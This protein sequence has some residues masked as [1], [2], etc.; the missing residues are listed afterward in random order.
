LKRILL[1]AMV[2]LLLLGCSGASSFQT[3]NTTMSIT[4]TNTTV[5]PGHSF[6]ITITISNANNLNGWQVALKY[7]A[8]IVNCTAAWI[9]ADN[10]FAN[11]SFIAV[12]P[13]LNDATVDG[14]NYS[15]CGNGLFSDDSV[16]VAQGTLCKLNFTCQKYGW[17]SLQLGTPSNPIKSGSVYLPTSWY[18]ELLDTNPTEMDFVAEDGFV[19]NGLQPVLTVVSSP[20]GTTNPSPGNYSRTA[21]TNAS[22]VATPD[23]THTFDHWL[24]D[25]SN[26]GSTNLI[27]VL[28]NANHTVEPV[29]AQANFALTIVEAT[30]GNTS[31]LPGTYTYAAGYLLQISATAYSGYVFSYW[32]LDGSQAGSSNPLPVTMNSNHTLRPVF[33]STL[34]A[35]IYI[36]VDGTIDPPGVPLS[37]LDNTTYEFTGDISSMITVQRSNITILG[38][39][40]SLQGTGSGSGIRLIGVN[41]VSIANLNIRGFDNGIDILGSSLDTISECNI[42]ANNGMGINLYNSCNNTASANNIE[43]NNEAIHLDYSSNYNSVIGNNIE[44]NGVRGIYV[45]SSSENLVYHNNFVNNT[46]Q[47]Y[48]AASGYSPSNSWDNGM[49]GNYWSNYLGADFNADGIGDTPYPIDANNTDHFP[50]LGTFSVFDATQG[51]SVAIVSNST[52]T[53]FNYS[54]LDKRI[55]FNVS[56]E[57][58]KIGFCELTIPH[59]L[60]DAERIEVVIDNGDTPSLF[61]NLTLRDNTTHRWIIIF[62]TQSAHTIVVQEDWTPPSI[63]LLSPENKPFPT[64]D[65]SLNLT[66]NDQTS[67]IGYS[68]DDADNVT[69]SGN[70]TLHISSDGPHSVIVYA[71]DT[72]GNMGSSAIVTFE[73]DTAPP[74]IVSLIQTPPESNI[75]PDEIVAINVTIDDNVTGV[76]TVYLNYTCTNTSGTFSGLILMTNTQGNSWNATLPG[77]PNGTNLTYMIVAE[78]NVGN[79]ASSIQ[80][81][82]SYL[83]VVPEYSMLMAMSLLAACSFLALAL[84]KRKKPKM[85]TGEKGTKR[86]IR[87]LSSVT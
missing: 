78:D 52:I 37:T 25:G 30:G 48:V 74:E 87:V 62:Y 5:M 68:L 61:T 81:Q 26:A 60:I 84:A 18:S 8:S 86:Q 49:E 41:N 76:K 45:D 58:G 28:M 14:Y 3:A 53:D 13:T 46:N 66:I 19:D 83:D 59:S 9:P 75:M 21:W 38:N 4:P 11:H 27:T 80:R 20:N 55:S 39:A 10:V 47:A 50:L 40:H 42:T 85:R 54:S 12:Q 63:V 35:Y 79:I 71:N 69:V 64:R 82:L 57:S 44:D 6:T 29:F 24:L 15:I 22:V 36:R 34:Y 33:L 51:C 7:D 56:G 31:M 32:M 23:T 70:L 2:T 17:A 1:G 72:S 73:I 65:V 16:N 77:F 67:W 43:A